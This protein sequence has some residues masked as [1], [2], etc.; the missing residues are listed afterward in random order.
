MMGK[1]SSYAQ[2]YDSTFYPADSNAIYFFKSKLD[3]YSPLELNPLD[4]TLYD[5][6]EYNPL[7]K[8]APFHATLGNVG[9]AYHNLDFGINRATGFDYG[10]HTFDAYYFFNDD[11][12]YYVNPKPYTEVGYITGAKKEQLFNVKHD[13]RIFKRLTFGLD[14]DLINSLGTY[15]RQKS[16]NNK[17]AVKMHYFTENLRYGVLANYTHS[18]VNVRENGG[19]L[20]DSIYE[21]NLEPT[22]SIIPIKLSDADN[23]LR[24]SGLYLQQYFQLSRKNMRPPEDST[25]APKKFQLKFGRIAHSFSYKRHSMVY[26]DGLP[27]TNYYQNIYIDSTNTYDSVYFQKVENTF[28]WSNSD[29]LNRIN[30][31]PFVLLFGI[32]HQVIGVVDSLSSDNFTNIAPYAEIKIRPL[33]L[34]SVE[35]KGSYIVTGEDY[36]GDFDLSGLAKLE[37]MRKKPYKTTFNFAFELDNHAAPYF[38]RHYFSNHFMWDN[39]FNKVKTNKISMFLTQRRMRVGFDLY[40]I[41]DYIYIGADTLPKQF[42][43]SVEILKAYLYK[44][45]RLG[46]FDVDGRLIYQKV[47]EKGIIRLPELMAYFTFTFNLKMFKG[48]LHSRAGFDVNYFTKYY[49][50]A[51]MPAIR[52]FYIQDNKEVGGYLHVDFFL[53]FNVKRTRFF[54]KFQNLTAAFGESN[55]Y[56]VPHYPMQDMAF[57]FGLSWRF[58]D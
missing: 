21:Q 3:I 2:N 10:I 4:T 56:Q 57:K 40:K 9:M 14:F 6:E 31:Q 33:P 36:Q 20:Y 44:Q 13:Q 12:D 42:G 48:A 35:G 55:F 17:L 23:L 25:A 16:D 22:R 11:L 54:M 7:A 18:K 50:N 46:K 51:Y 47:S 5:F 45:F 8:K 37:I 38:Y 34:L 29:Y 39:G 27:D 32:K 24:K 15:Q 53:D 26:T 28:S 1:Q 58:H 43:Q 19:I 41:Q 52:S 49:A 30:P